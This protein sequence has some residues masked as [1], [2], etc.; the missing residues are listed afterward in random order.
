[1][2]DRNPARNGHVPRSLKLPEAVSR[3]ITATLSHTRP[4]SAAVMSS[5]IISNLDLAVSPDPELSNR[6]DSSH[7]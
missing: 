1:M 7:S 6:L 4:A 2:T 3:E 5:F